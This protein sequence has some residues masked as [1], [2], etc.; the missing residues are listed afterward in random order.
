MNLSKPFRNFSNPS[1]K[2]IKKSSLINFSKILSAAARALSAA[3]SQ[4]SA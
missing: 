3:A 1:S 2:S 4:P